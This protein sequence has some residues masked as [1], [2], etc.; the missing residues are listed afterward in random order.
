MWIVS[1]PRPIVPRE[2]DGMNARKLTGQRILPTA[3]GACLLEQDLSGQLG[4][5]AR[6]E[7]IDCDVQIDVLPHRN[8][9]RSLGAVARHF[10]LLCPPSLYQLAFYPDLSLGHSHH[11][12]LF[13]RSGAVVLPL[14]GDLPPELEHV[15]LVQA[16]LEAEGPV[17]FG[18]DQD[19]SR[20]PR[21]DL[22]EI[23]LSDLPDQDVLAAL[24]PDSE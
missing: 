18:P 12:S 20:Q 16:A 19:I 6:R 4:R 24:E 2:G 9:R 21:L 10:E 22:L 14:P 13:G 23:P 17:S 8:L 3:P 11:T 1:G 5:A 15:P 7:E